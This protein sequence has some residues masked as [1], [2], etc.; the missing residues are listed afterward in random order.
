MATNTYY[1]QD[2]TIREFGLGVLEVNFPIRAAAFS[3][4]AGLQPRLYNDLT[5][6]G[7]LTWDAA[8]EGGVFI[9]G[10]LEVYD[11]EFFTRY[12]SAFSSTRDWR[13]QLDTYEV[14]TALLFHRWSNRHGMIRFL[15]NDPDWTLVYLDEVAVIFVRNRGNEGRIAKARELYPAWQERDILGPACTHVPLAATRRSRQGARQ[16]CSDPPLDRP[17]GTAIEIYERLLGFRLPPEQE[18]RIRIIIGSY[19]GN[20]GEMGK[21][22]GHLERAAELDPS[23]RPLQEMIRRSSVP[24]PNVR[25]HARAGSS[26]FHGK[27]KGLSRCHKVNFPNSTSRSH[28]GL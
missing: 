25:T 5:A 28:D 14:N 2:G 13:Q 17:N 10:R 3:R 20:K 6:G 11:T 23:N 1:W 9:D 22:L 12:V 19:H 26:R 27:G 21:A 24:T 8:V 7:Y 15:M 16:L 18:G 4:D